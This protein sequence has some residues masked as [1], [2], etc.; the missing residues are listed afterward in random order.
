M[1]QPEIRIRYGWF[2]DGLFR[3]LV[4][5][6]PEIKNKNYP[7][8]KRIE[9]KIEDYKKT[10]KKIEAKALSGICQVLDLE[11]YQH[12]IDVYIVGRVRSFSDPLVIS[13]HFEPNEFC[14]ILIHELIH[15]ILTDNTRHIDVHSI[16]NEMFPG[17]P[18]L[19]LNHVLVHAVHEYIYRDVM[20]DV[21]RLERDIKRSNRPEYKRSWDI[22]KEKGYRQVMER[23][24]DYYKK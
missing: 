15:R 3:R 11:F 7:S 6:N 21:L 19:V 18:R 5:L 4:E 9:Q 2:L 22:V 17:E 13:S 1:K 8:Q 23:F 20:K 14:D 10:W 24:K 16:W 12:L